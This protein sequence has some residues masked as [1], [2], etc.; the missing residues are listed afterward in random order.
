MKIAI[1]THNRP[2]VT[3]LNLL[4]KVFNCSDIHLFVNDEEQAELYSSHKGLCEIVV[5]HTKGIQKARNAILDYFP[6]DEYIV[7]LDDDIE[8]VLKLSSG[9]RED[10]LV[11]KKLEHMDGKEIK[12]FME[13]AFKICKINSTKLWGI[14]PVMNP[15]FMSKKINNKGFIIGSFCGIINSDIR[16]DDNLP[17]KEDYQFTA[18]HIIKHKK[19]ARFDYV[20]AKIKHYTN[21]GGVVDLRNEKKTLEKLNWP[22]I[23]SLKMTLK[24]YM[25]ALETLMTYD[26]LF[27]ML[28]LHQGTGL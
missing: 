3:T 22:G 4:N 7:M 13:Y 11:K 26:H 18:D 9:T 17:L 19:I 2:N 15:F 21:T 14:Y 28:Q 23:F 12:E 8:E 24:T 27:K 6:K 25:Q 5:T 1:P 10:G 16:F 20:T